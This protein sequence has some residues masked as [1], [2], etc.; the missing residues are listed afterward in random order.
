MRDVFQPFQKPEEGTREQPA[1][2]GFKPE[3][4]VTVTYQLVGETLVTHESKIE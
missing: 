3:G 2:P 4:E 1:T